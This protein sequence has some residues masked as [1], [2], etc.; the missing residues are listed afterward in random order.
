MITW[1]TFFARRKAFTKAIY[2][3]GITKAPIPDDLEEE[4]EIYHLSKE[5]GISPAE[6]EVLT[7]LQR[8]LMWGYLE[9][10]AIVMKFKQS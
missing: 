10:Q 2:H 1:P 4:F 7:P 6:V 8:Q 5:W 9:G 3:A